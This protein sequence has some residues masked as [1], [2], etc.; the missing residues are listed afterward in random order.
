MDIS[1]KCNILCI[2][3]VLLIV[4]FIYCMIKYSSKG[5]LRKNWISIFPILFSLIALVNC[6]PRIEQLGFDYLGL[7]VG[8]LALLVTVLIGWNIYSVVDFDS[9]KKEF[10]NVINS[11]KKEIERMNNVIDTKYEKLQNEFNNEIECKSSVCKEKHKQIINKCNSEKSQIIEYI[12]N[13]YKEC[14]S[15]VDSQIQIERKITFLSDF[16]NEAMKTSQHETEGWKAFKSF[17]YIATQAKDTGRKVLIEQALQRADEVKEK[18]EN[19]LKVR[20]SNDKSSYEILKDDLAD[21]EIEEA[22]EI[23]K[24]IENALHVQSSAKKADSAGQ[25][26]GA[27]R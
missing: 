7:I 21:I 9:K 20:I 18:F 26:E 24:F 4:A 22:R 27:V 17:C 19:E 3:L 14:K 23:V 1:I 5:C 13:Q 25:G 10:N 6:Y 11:M 8:I 2:V 15:Y 16:Y 12:N